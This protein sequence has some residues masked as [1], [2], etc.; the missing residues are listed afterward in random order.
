MGQRI[1]ILGFG[2]MGEPIAENLNAQG[3]EVLAYDIS[4]EAI[5]RM[6]DK[7][8][9]VTETPRKLAEK[10]DYVLDILIDSSTTWEVLRRPGGLLEGLRTSAVVIDMTT[11]DPRESIAIGKFLN[12]RKIEYLD[13]PITGGVIGA[14]TRDLVVMVGGNKEVFER[15]KYILEAFAKKI[16][17]MGELG[18]GHYMKLIHNQLSHSV[19]LATCEAA[20]LGMSVGLSLETLIE[21][22]NHGNAKSY[23]TEVRF[24]RFILSGAFDA[25]ASF[26]TVHKDIG[27]VLKRMREL[28][29]EFPI[30]KGTFD[31]WDYPVKNG[32][33]ENDYTTI[34]N[35]MEQICSKEGKNE[36]DV[37]QNIEFH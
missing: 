4:P 33:G 24:P 36:G 28:N 21:V 12:E 3:F 27:I 17:Y 11:S 37:D 34:F 20:F 2:K 18:T 31:Y 29:Y 5:R 15:C 30:T 35:L 23:A 6:R 26:R 14:K 13:A 16:F 1:G 10:C 25:G 7:S 32:L 22:F 8:I 19:F 9:Q